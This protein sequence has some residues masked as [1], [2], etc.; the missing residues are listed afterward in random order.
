M[1]WTKHDDYALV[2]DCGRYS[3]A[4]IGGKDGVA[5]E[6]WRRRTHPAGPGLVEHGI[7][8]SRQARK[9]AERDSSTIGQSAE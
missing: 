9:I 3:V 2:S 5:Y 1:K 7:I 6:V 8:D 4:K